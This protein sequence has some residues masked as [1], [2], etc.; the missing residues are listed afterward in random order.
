MRVSEFPRLEY[1]NRLSK[2]QYR[3]GEEQINGLLIT[4]E[5]NFRE[6]SIKS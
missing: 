6:S 3:M 2:I 4:S 1:E 5:P